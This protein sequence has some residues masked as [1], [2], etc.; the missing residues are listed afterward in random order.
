MARLMPVAIACAIVIGLSVT[1]RAPA[2][3]PSANDSGA[4]I[5]SAKPVRLI[6]PYAPG[7][8]VY[9]MG[10]IIAAKLAARLGAQVIVT[11]PLE[12]VAKPMAAFV[13]ETWPPA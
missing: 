11:A 6:V 4:Q 7:G 10:R 2:Q 5:F 12:P 9:I 3:T 8:G 1:G 13:L